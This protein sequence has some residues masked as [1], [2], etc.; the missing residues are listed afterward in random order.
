MGTT[1]GGP[2]PLKFWSAKNLQ[3]ST[4]FRTTSYFDR[5]YLRNASGERRYQLLSLPRSE[6]KPGNL[7]ST[8]HRVYAA[9][10]YPPE[11]NTARAA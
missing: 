6:K 1:F 3:N 4:R 7:W 10:V 5:E 2:T 8:N 11:M 9:N